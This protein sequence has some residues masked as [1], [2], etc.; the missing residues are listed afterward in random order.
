M[1]AI[2][3][4]LT[5]FGL[6]DG[7]GA[8]MKGVI[9]T[10]NPQATIVDVTHEVPPQDVGYGAYILGTVYPYFPPG[11]IHVA[12]VDPGVGS[13]RAA[14]AVQAAGQTF[15]APDNG[16]LTH[17]LAEGYDAAVALTEPRFWR[18]QPART[19]HGRDIFAPVAAHLSL[20]VPLAS[21]GEP[22]EE[23]VRLPLAQPH[24]RADGTW[25]APAWLERLQG[26]QVG[27]AIIHAVVGTYADVPSGSPAILVGSGGYLEIALRDGSAQ[28]EFGAGVGS[29]V[30]LFPM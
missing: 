9:L 17:V 4:L 30:L 16:L 11:T 23:L 10:L 25:V 19:F 14:V 26:A 28:R 3:T 24:R 5:D 12:V 13:A 27:S 20:G 21:L 15:V 6:V 18:P 1:A 29:E 8:A 2:I 22:V 7:Y